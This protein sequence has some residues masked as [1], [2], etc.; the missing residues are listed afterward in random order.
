[1][2]VVEVVFIDTNH[3]LVVANFVPHTGGERELGLH[4]VPK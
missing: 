2:K 3:F 1:M 4:L